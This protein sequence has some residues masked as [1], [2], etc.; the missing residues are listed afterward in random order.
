MVGI[1]AEQLEWLGKWRATA[2]LIAGG[3]FVIDAA[4][5]VAIVG[6]GR[7]ELMLVGQAFIGAGWTAAFIGLI[8][9][10]PDIAPE[11]PWLARAGSVLAALGVVVFGVM[12][13][14][15][16]LYFADIPAGEITD[17]VPIFLPGVILGSVVGFITMGVAVLR[18]GTISRVSGVLFVILG[19]FP[20][21]NIA[22]GAAGYQ[23][24]EATLV[25]VG[26]LI[27]LNMAIAY[28]LHTDPSP[29]HTVSPTEPVS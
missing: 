12:A 27:V 18:A 23:S 10:Y 29:S 21:A 26:G 20:V 16:L 7:E 4:I 3:M 19:L 5:L 28:T 24:E 11:S 15:S 14:V 6:G 1:T 8:G 9:T 25:I 2:F 13:I 17:V 22:R